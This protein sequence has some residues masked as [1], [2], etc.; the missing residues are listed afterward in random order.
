MACCQS[1]EGAV[2]ASHPLLTPPVSDPPVT[3][4]VTRGHRTGRQRRYQYI[5]F[6]PRHPNPPAILQRY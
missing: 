6:N 3:G 4:T 1:I 5:Q 2:V